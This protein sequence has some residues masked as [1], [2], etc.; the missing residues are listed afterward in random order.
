MRFQT[1][2]HDVFFRSWWAMAFIL[3]CIILYEQGL[4]KRDHLYRQ[5]NEQSITL[6]KEKGEALREQ[7]N[8]QLQINSQDDFAWME[9]T[10]MK[11]LGLVPES[12]QKVFFFQDSNWD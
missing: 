6:L 2:I 9:L 10:L 3:G 11:V 7:Q 12:Q 4:K 8:L 1:I 5:L